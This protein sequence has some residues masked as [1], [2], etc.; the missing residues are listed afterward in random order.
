[1]KDKMKITMPPK[2][3]EIVKRLQEAGYEAYAVGG[4]IRDSI[5]DKEPND[6]DICTSA[7][8]QETKDCFSEYTVV[9]TG[10]Q[11]GTVTVVIEHEPYEVTTYRVDGEYKDNRRPEQVQFVSELK[12]DLA[13]RDFTI[14]AMAYCEEDGLKDFFG[15]K[16]DLQS[17]VIRC[18]GDANKRFQE[19]ALR[20]FRALRF[21]S[22]LGFEIEEDTAKAIREEK[23]LLKNIAKE[24]I[25]VELVKLLLGD[26][27]KDILKE[28]SDVIA[29]IIP[30]IKDMIGFEQHNPH[31]CYDVWIHTIEALSHTPADKVIRLASLLHDSGKPH[32]Y[33]CDDDGIGHF[34]GHAAKSFDIAQ[35]VMNRLKFDNETKHDVCQLVKY[36]DGIVLGEEKY[37]KRW[38][39]KM[40]EV[41]FQRLLKLKYGDMMGQSEL[42]RDSKLESLRGLDSIL[43][44]VLDEEQCF[45]LKDLNINGRDLIDIGIK[46][47]K[48]I[49]KILDKLLE[50]VIDGK[51]DNQKEV[52][53][54]RVR[55]V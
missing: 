32:C 26:G 53:L 37:V 16:N 9:E 50:E 44:K 39:N 22:V 20:I 43:T 54:E 34:Y 19:D 17:G 12:E 51:L 30:E 8:P 46:E 28:Y 31:H 7:K 42:E 55:E 35:T 38:L 48:K 52:L 29:V 3:K 13:R 45:S 40:G 41:Q 14:N 33:T 5:L 18:V 21:A 23:M 49:G 11:H 36:H 27:A 47:G 25:Q 1:M 6:W 4:C 10:I 15:G 24:R 2:V